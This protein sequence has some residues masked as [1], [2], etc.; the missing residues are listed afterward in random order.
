[1]TCSCRA[2]DGLRSGAS[3]AAI[4]FNRPSQ[5]LLI[6]RR[7]AHVCWGVEYVRPQTDPAP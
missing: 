1:M 6:C 3:L 7:D 2:L 4:M 5:A